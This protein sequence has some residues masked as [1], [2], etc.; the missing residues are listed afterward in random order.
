M[1]DALCLNTSQCSIDIGSELKCISY[2]SASWNDSKYQWY[3]GSV[4]FVCL[5]IPQRV[6][7]LQSHFHP[8]WKKAVWH[9]CLYIFQFQDSCIRNNLTWLLMDFFGWGHSVH[10]QF[11]AIIKISI[12]KY[13]LKDKFTFVLVCLKMIVR[14]PNGLFSNNWSLLCFIG[15]G[16]PL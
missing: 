7:T 2:G 13:K 9:L 1:W 10:S 16:F 5:P 8:Y 12:S 11:S 3:A 14:C 6:Q 4:R 15:Q